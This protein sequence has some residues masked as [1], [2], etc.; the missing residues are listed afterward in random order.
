MNN[1][2]H[3]KQLRAKIDL[4]LPHLMAASQAIVNHQ[5]FSEFYPEYLFTIHCM[6]RASVPLMEAALERARIMASDDPVA[7]KMTEYLSKHISE[8]MHHDDWLL[9][10]LEVLGIDRSKL[11]RRPPSPSVVNMVGS[12]YYWIHHYH[13]VAL[14]GYIAVVE[15]HPPTVKWIEEQVIRTGLPRAA[16][17]TLFKHAQLDPHHRDDLNKT[18][19]HLPLVQE[20]SAIL[21]ISA[22]HTVSWA[23]SAF[24]EII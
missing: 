18:L 20:H 4:V 9:E 10:D 5:R 3:S 13:P 2:S 11:L 17:R 21:G 23:S 15:G 22:M 6:I 14:L 7:D 1:I 24:H 19:D 16:F 8:E 12:Q